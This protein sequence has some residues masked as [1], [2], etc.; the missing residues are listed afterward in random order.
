MAD[1]TGVGIFKDEHWAWVFSVPVSLAKNSRQNGGQKWQTTRVDSE[2]LKTSR[3]NAKNCRGMTNS[4]E[5]MSM[6]QI[7][8]KASTTYW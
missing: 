5:T 1:A 2:Q 8:T 6:L 3:I 4:S 7:G